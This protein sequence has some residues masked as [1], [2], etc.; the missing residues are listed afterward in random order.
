MDKTLSQEIASTKDGNRLLQEERAIL[1]VTELICELMEETGVSRSELAK[2][3]GKTKGYI[4]QLLDGR[5]NMTI[6]TIANVFGALGRAVH[7]R[8]DHSQGQ[9]RSAQI[10]WNFMTGVAKESL[11]ADANSLTSHP[12]L[13]SAS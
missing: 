8:D 5:A 11:A 12:F 7:F 1:E 4:T 3:L 2:R 13:G 6:R 9:V 10:Q